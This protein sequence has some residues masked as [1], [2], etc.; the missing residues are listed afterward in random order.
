MRGIYLNEL[1]G[2]LDKDIK[3]QIK[4]KQNNE[5]RNRFFLYNNTRMYSEFGNSKI[6]SMSYILKSSLFV[7]EVD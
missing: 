3:I 6:K 4:F 7:I 5:Y 2:V 1:N